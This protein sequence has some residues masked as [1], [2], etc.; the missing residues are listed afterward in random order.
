MTAVLLALPLVT[1]AQTSSAPGTQPNRNVL[2]A[3]VAGP[4]TCPAER[5]VYELRVPDSADVWRIELVPA[6]N[7]RSIASDLYLKLIT[8]VRTYWFKFEVSQGYSGISVLPVTDPYSKGGSKDLLGPPFGDNPE[9]TSEIDV[10][11]ALRF[12]AFDETLNVLFE[13]PVS[14][15]EAPP[16]M[17]LP[18]IG[19]ALWYDTAALT[20]APGADRDPMPRGMFK[21]TGCLVAPHRPIVD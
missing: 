8:Q 14:G 1:Y 3:P 16:L 10:L 7:T 15:D 2:N 9:G 19:R 4:A 6:Q 18:E 11:S 5:G 17:M 12:L 13:P 21:R 20:D